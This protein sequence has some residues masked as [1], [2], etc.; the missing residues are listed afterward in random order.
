VNTEH[1]PGS[2]RDEN[3]EVL[4]TFSQTKGHGNLLLRLSKDDSNPGDFR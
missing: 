3:L 1:S 2:G 4:S